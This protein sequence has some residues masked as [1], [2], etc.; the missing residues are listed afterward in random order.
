PAVRVLARRYGVIDLP[1]ARR[2]HQHATARG[3]GVA[4]VFAFQL[5]CLMAVAFPWPKLGGGLDFAWWQRFALASLVLFA[6]GVIDDV[7][8][9]KPVVKLGGQALT[10]LLMALSG[11]HFGTYDPQTHHATLM[12]H[13]LPA[14][15]DCALVV[16]WLVAI[17]NA[18]NLIDGLD[19]LASGLA[20]ISAVGLCGIL[21]MQKAP[22]DVL[23]LLGFI[24]ACLGFL[25]YN[26]HPASIFL[27][28]TGSMFI[29]FT[30][31]VVSLQ[32]FN[33][34]SFLISLTIPMLVLGVPIYDA[35]L[36]IWR[37]SVRKWTDD[38]A[39][40]T[41][42]GIMQPDL[43]HLHHRLKLAGLSTGRVAAYLCVLNAA[44]VMV[45]LLITLF[46]SHAAGIF[47]IALLAGVYVVMRHLAVIELRE[48]GRAL[49]MGLRRPTHSA[50]KALMYPFWDMIWL[51]GLLAFIMWEFEKLR[52]D[53]WH[54]WFYDLPVWVTPTFSLLAIS[55]TYVTYWPRARLRDVLMMVFWLQAGILFSL[56]LALVIDPAEA[57]KWCVRALLV[58]GIGHP[59]IIGSR[60]IYRCIEELMLW[61]RRQ[62]EAGSDV[63]R[64]LLYGAGERAQLFL[65]D[66]AVRTSRQADS[67]A[68]VGFID[69][70]KALHFQWVY[71]QLV[72]GGIADL[73]HLAT[74]LQI[75][76]IIIVADLD[77]ER[78][79]T[80]QSIVAASG[81]VLSEWHP[82]ERQIFLAAPEKKQMIE[83]MA[84]SPAD[85]N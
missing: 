41:K 36:A 72:L 79:R 8:G 34:N 58:G 74:S 81:M 7:R 59:I 40:G 13:I 76:R 32:T 53:F 65:K 33:K 18:F 23:V 66:R 60:L 21:L 19:G 1:N 78:R 49:L 25:R 27:G 83:Q 4:V 62:S 77:P 38:R 46:Q 28:D 56:G 20:I 54:T 31:G 70:E 71:G 6:V 48:T 29:G 17:I 10:A 61:I 82:E 42:R 14:P 85:V 9:L 84:P 2:P 55:R 64:T 45:G 73:P 43:E 39:S 68:I 37:R 51:A 5:A 16:L 52:V 30:L 75:K 24:G 80:L 11:T 63:E 69:D 57:H 22:G 26:F 67:R 44:L 3:G 50:L 15:V 35:M 12:G 47:L